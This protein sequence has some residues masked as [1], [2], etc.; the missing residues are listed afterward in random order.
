MRRVLAAFAA[1]AAFALPLA[2]AHGADRAA[3]VETRAFEASP[4]MSYYGDAAGLGSLARV[5]SRFRVIDVDLD[6][7]T[8]NFTPAEVAVL[9]NGGRNIVLSYLNLGSCET[10]RSYWREAPAGFVSCAANTAAHA[11]MYCG[12]GQEVW[13]NLSNAAYRRLIV[14]YVAPRLVA[15]GADGFYLD[16][17]EIVEHGTATRNGPCDAACAQGG[18]DLVREL[19]EKYPRLV[20][21]MQNATGRTTREGSTGGVA[22]AALLDGVA[23]EEVYA[24]KYDA[25]AEAELAVWQA[26][27]LT[28]NGHAFWIATLDY[29]GGC[30]A[31]TRAR[32]VFAR[33]RA[34]GFVPYASDSSARQGVVCY[35][36][37]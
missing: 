35:W 6:P 10:W 7:G 13:M 37:K 3:A 29:V 18:L 23:H 17:L 5:A 4:W 22:F 19:R 25:S 21:V 11:G 2:G 9:K 28:P 20:F 15:Q 31:S 33:S 27:T 8:D 12:Y 26:M 30:D 1:F 34:K 24:P 36:G 16:N 14:D 32:R